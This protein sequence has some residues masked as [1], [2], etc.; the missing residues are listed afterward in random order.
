M[1]TPTPTLVITGAA[2]G[3]GGPVARAALDAGYRVVA[4]DRAPFDLPGAA[5]TVVGDL[6]EQG[7][8]DELFDAAGDD[9]FA[10]LHLA[11]IPS[12]GQF[13]DHDTLVRNV[14]SAYR[15][16][17]TAGERGVRRI[18][19][20]SS[21]SAVGFAWADR[22]L[23]PAYLPVDEDH[24][25]VVVD[26]YGLSKVFMEQ[27]A[28]FTERRW[29]VPTIT[30]RFPFVG[31]GDRLQVRLDEMA[32]SPATGSR[33][34]WAWVDTRDA[35]TSILR[36]AE[37]PSAGAVVLNVSAPDTMSPWPTREIVAA[38]FP[39]LEVPDTVAE[40]G[41]LYD[42]SRAAELLGLTD[43]HGWRTGA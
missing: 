13:D 43:Y 16:L 18:V 22:D 6:R 41:G 29:H 27:I 4:A 11:A 26:T 20:V 1:T 40:Y 23:T 25:I 37:V 42:T 33:D 19:A 35:V 7:V 28:A 36:S 30:L 21:A 17:G 12:P 5:A 10:V 14:S 38:A 39:G 32:Q 9:V 3:I 2:G 34:L 31:T 24:P 8:V 15:V